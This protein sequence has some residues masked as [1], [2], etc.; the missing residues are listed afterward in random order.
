MGQSILRNGGHSL[1]L[2]VAEITKVGCPKTE[3]NCHGA[4]IATL[5]LQ[6]VCSVFGTHLSTG[7]I[8]AASTHQL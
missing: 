3:E 1:E 2:V 7:D 4:T 6:E 5:V 8:G